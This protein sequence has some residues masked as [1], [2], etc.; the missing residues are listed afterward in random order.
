MNFSQNKSSSSMQLY[1]AY[2]FAELDENYSKGRPANSGGYGSV[3]FV[4]WLHVHSGFSL[5]I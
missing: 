3:I 4:L 1:I 2:L 5:L